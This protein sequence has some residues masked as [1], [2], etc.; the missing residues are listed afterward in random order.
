MAFDIKAKVEEIVEMIKKDPKLITEF[1]NKP[2]PTVEKLIGVDLP[3]DTIMKIVELVKA[4][5]D[6]DKVSNM[7]GGLGG[8]FGKK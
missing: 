2:I 8:L 5:L 7:L 1:Q 3:D 4:K 6:M